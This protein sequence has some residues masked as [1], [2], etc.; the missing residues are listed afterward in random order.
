MLCNAAK[1]WTVLYVCRAWTA[2]AGLPAEGATQDTLWHLFSISGAAC[3]QL[4][5]CPA[6]EGPA[7]L[8]GHGLTQTLMLDRCS[9]CLSLRWHAASPVVAP[10]ILSIPHDAGQGAD[11]SLPP[12]G[13]TWEAARQHVASLVRQ[14]CADFAVAAVLQRGTHAGQAFE[15]ALHSIA[16][17]STRSSIALAA[18]PGYAMQ[19][20]HQPAHSRRDW[21]H[22]RLSSYQPLLQAL[23]VSMPA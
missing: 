17:G 7:Q 8:P 20:Q 10:W 15:L 1:G 12:A 18:T 6:G 16:A 13:K 5:A 11:L 2:L 22:C 14:E 19:V 4:H 23:L 21:P 3:A 9:C